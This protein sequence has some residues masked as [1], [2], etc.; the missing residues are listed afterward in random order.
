[1]PAFASSRIGEATPP[2]MPDGVLIY[3]GYPRAS[4]TTPFVASLPRELVHTIPELK[5][6]NSMSDAEL[7]QNC[8]PGSACTL[9]WRL[10]ATSWVQIAPKVTEPWAPP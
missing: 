7:C 3:F 8:R 10:S 9:G 4:K 5:F 1:M 6:P 2:A